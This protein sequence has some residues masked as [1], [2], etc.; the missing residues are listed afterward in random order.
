[1]FKSSG[2]SRY[3]DIYFFSTDEVSSELLLRQLSI[4]S[5]LYLFH[6]LHE[7]FER[8]FLFLSISLEKSLGETE[9]FFFFFIYFCITRSFFSSL[10]FSFSLFIFPSLSSIYSFYISSFISSS[11]CNER[12]EYFPSISLHLY[13]FFFF[14]FFISLYLHERLVYSRETFLFISHWGFISSS[15]VI[16]FP[17]LFLQRLL[18]L[19]ISIRAF[20]R[21]FSFI[22]Q[23][24]FCIFIEYL[25][26][27]IRIF[28]FFIT[29]FLLRY[30]REFSFISSLRYYLFSFA[31]QISSLSLLSDI[32]F[33]YLFSMSLLSDDISF[34][35]SFIFL[36]FI[37]FLRLLFS[38]LHFLIF[39]LRP[40]FSWCWL[41]I[42]FLLMIFLIYWF[43]F[44]YFLPSFFLDFDIWFT[45]Y[46]DDIFFHSIDFRY[47]ISIFLFHF[48]FLHFSFFFFSIIF[49]SLLIF[50]PFSAI[51]SSASLIADAIR[52]LISFDFHCFISIYWRWLPLLLMIFLRYFFFWY[53]FFSFLIDFFI[54]ADFLFSLISIFLS[55]FSLIYFLFMLF[56]YF[57]FRLFHFSTDFLLLPFGLLSSS[58]IFFDFFSIFH[59]LISSSTV[60][61]R[62]QLHQIISHFLRFS[63]IDCIAFLLH[64]F[65]IS[66]FISDVFSL[67]ISFSDFAVFSIFFH[68]LLWFLPI[69]SFSDFDIWLL[70]EAEHFIFLLHFSSI[71]FI[72][73][74]FFFFFICNDIYC[75]YDWAWHC[76]LSIFWFFDVFSL[77]L[78][79]LFIYYDWFSRFLHFSE[80]LF[81][82]CLIFLQSFF[83]ESFIFSSSLYWVH[84]F[85]WFYFW[86]S[87][88]SLFIYFHVIFFEFHFLFI[89]FLIHSSD[90][91]CERFSLMMRWWFYFLYLFHF[92]V[93]RLQFIFNSWLKYFSLSFFLFYIDEFISSM[94]WGLQRLLFLFISE[95]FSISLL[96][97]EI[98]FFDD[99][100]GH[101][102]FH[103]FLRLLLF[104]C[105]SFLRFLSFFFCCWV[106]ESFHFF[107]SSARDFFIFI[108][109]D[110]RWF[111]FFED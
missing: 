58:S 21:H 102:R 80:Y 53:F 71:I 63:L 109:I 56:I 100:D 92:C 41:F 52:L 55:L 22:Y 104:H 51:D 81:R 91:Y 54:S 79:S 88:F 85:W 28:I 64:F 31:F 34:S 60:F 78:Q 18:L 107:S 15:L 59:F 69:F 74:F 84:F 62:F 67:F 45:F 10:F 94:R 9:N 93:E 4:L 110:F 111:S 39:R 105:I 72:Y 32:S 68:F 101:F 61:F 24:C 83:V 90:I 1:L 16:D 82:D 49:F 99:F 33:D 98:D 17:F 89:D 66:S 70:I 106:F 14:F 48:R 7:T 40:R 47:F 46:F 30:F 96:L 97:L 26:Q 103:L 42:S 77:F 29:I 19:E 11:Y 5:L 57:F 6:F 38:L 44:I 36:L 73:F 75:H 20:F 12:D 50:S 27:I 43:F 76:W 8:Q 23:R 35:S 95:I 86:L 65:D 3:L 87:L 13:F 2:F 25:R 37:R 108:Q